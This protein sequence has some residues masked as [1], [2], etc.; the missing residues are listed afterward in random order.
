MITTRFTL[1]PLLASLALPLSAQTVTTLLND[2]F[3]DLDRTNQA[4]PASSAWFTS[5]STVNTNIDAS[6]GALVVKNALTNL[7]YFTGAGNAVNLA[8]GE[9]L[10]LSFNVSFSAVADAAASFRVGLYSSGTRISADN[11][12]NTNSA[13]SGSY[14]GYMGGVNIG[15][16]GSNIFRVYERGTSTSLISGSIGTSGY[17]LTGSGGGAVKT[18]VPDTVYSAVMTITRVDASTVSISQSYSGIFSGDSVTSTASATI[19][20]TSGVN[21][22]FDTL[23][24]YY[25]NTANLTFDNIK[26]DYS[27]IPEPSTFAFLAGFGALACVAIRRRRNT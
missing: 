23:A 18:F 3:T 26:L 14:S 10:T 4:L 22:S 20:D 24:F 6:G 13:F 5:G 15:S 11:F 21:T 8:N 27:A 2:T 9:S 16:T 12:G 17:A 25:N 1:L 19:S 7:T